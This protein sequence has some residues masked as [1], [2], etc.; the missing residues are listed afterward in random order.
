MPP[1]SPLNPRLARRP[2]G[3]WARPP[4]SAGPPRR[5]HARGRPV[6]V[7]ARNSDALDKPL[8]P[9][10]PAP[11]RCHWTRADRQ[12]VQAAAPRCWPG[13]LDAWCT[14]PALPRDAR[15][16]ARPGRNAAPRAGQLCGRLHLL[17]AVLPHM[18][19][20]RRPRRPHQP[21]QQRGGLPRPAQEPGLWPDQGGADQP[22]RR[23]CTW[24][25]TTGHGVS[26]DQPRLCGDAADRAERVH[27]AR[28][29]HART[30]G[31]RKSWRAGQRGRF[32]IHFPKRF[33]LWMKA[34]QLLPYRCT[35]R[36]APLYRAYISLSCSLARL[37]CSARQS[38]SGKRKSR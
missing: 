12:A 38:I 21:G 23:R 37:G 28:A 8:W 26:A 24:T 18:L 10:T 13:P 32:E 34:L 14:A 35:F 5:L 1:E 11:W 25:C 22:G 20:R 7:S 3:W 31:R 15:H 30:G 9:T 33:T 2:S 16:R 6:I 19:A 27:H 29:D 4:A 17:D 36:H